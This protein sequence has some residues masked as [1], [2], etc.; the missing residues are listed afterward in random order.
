MTNTLSDRS[1]MLSNVH[2]K[3]TSE[4]VKL[5]FRDWDIEKVVFTYRVKDYHKCLVEIYQIQKEKIIAIKSGCS[6]L[7]VDLIDHRIEAAKTSAE[8]IYSTFRGPKNQLDIVFLTF[9]SP[10]QRDVFLHK[11]SCSI[12]TRL[13]YKFCSCCS[14][15]AIKGQH[16]S[17]VKAPQPED[18]DWL[19][20]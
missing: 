9:Y 18:I 13:F 20:L 8:K 3:A 12:F 14:G 16:I 1:V 7:K 10:I 19:N 15:T 4:E 5:Q 11:F 17:V 2:Q 6:K